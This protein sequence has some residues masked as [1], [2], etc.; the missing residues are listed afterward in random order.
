MKKDYLDKGAGEEALIIQRPEDEAPGLVEITTYIRED[1]AL[2]L[3]IL[4]TAERQRGGQP[5]D[6]ARLVQE[7][8]DLLIKARIFPIKIRNQSAR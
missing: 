6:Q 2:A 1:Q 4:Q 5:C 7:A 3:D 8:L